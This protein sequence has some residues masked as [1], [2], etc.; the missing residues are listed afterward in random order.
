M[1]HARY[2]LLSLV[3]V[4]CAGNTQ[5]QTVTVPDTTSSG[6]QAPPPAPRDDVSEV[7]APSELVAIVRATNARAIS[8]R[9][10]QLGIATDAQARA[11]ADQ[12]L[13]EFLG[14]RELARA[15]S[16]DQPMD[17][18]VLLGAGRP[19]M[20]LSVGV[21]SPAEVSTRLANSFRA[22]PLGNGVIALDPVQSAQQQ[23][24]SDGQD[25]GEDIV[26]DAMH[27][28]LSPTPTEGQG[29][30][31]C[32]KGAESGLTLVTPFMARTLTRRQTREN[33]IVA[34]V[35]PV[36]MRAL[37]GREATAAFD[38]A[39]R[40]S[41]TMLS[42]Q[43]TGP[44]RHAELR[45]PLARLVGELIANG[46]ATF[47]EL[48]GI[49]MV[50]SMDNDIVRLSQSIELRAPSGSLVRAM[51]DGSRNVPAA[52][53]QHLER[54]A[55]DAGFYFSA[56]LSL[57]PF[58]A[59]LRTVSEAVV[60]LAQREARM[61]AAQ[62]A[63]LRQ[64]AESVTTMSATAVGG[65]VLANTGESSGVSVARF[66]TPA[67]ATAYV[68]DIRR[69]VGLLRSA[70]FARSMQALGTAF[71]VENVPDLRQVRELPTRGLPAGSFAYSLPDLSRVARGARPAARGA[72]P[73]P[74]QQLLVV[75]GDHVTV[76]SGVDMRAAWAAASAR[77]GA[78]PA[79]LASVPVRPG[80][81]TLAMMPSAI[82]NLF[83]MSQ[84]AGSS[85]PPAQPIVVPSQSPLVMRMHNADS[86]GAT[87]FAWDFEI[88]AQALTALVR[89]LAR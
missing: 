42:N 48:S 39:E 66:A 56:G 78:A 57:T 59:T 32:T 69:M 33:A 61:P 43:S 38:Q 60:V 74:T 79:A 75:E 89:T 24:A 11:A 20:V 17:M 30:L 40:Q 29:R 55:P 47:N 31:T 23:A 22:R 76:V 26:E 21:G 10:T 52:P 58:A 9:L 25:E 5:T 16:R 41:A 28:L 62:V 49:D 51:I 73:R 71:D 50:L 2:T 83:A 64:V 1:K 86:D 45:A 12:L 7:A 85:T 72:A 19:M 68:S 44:L 36:A 37:L 81:M 34:T 53:E 87:R 8:E 88:S 82:A 54:I 80:T 67:A 84:N 15:V 14:S 6:N 35:F 3:L 46:R 27:C 18:A 13:T 4:S 65:V 77:T 70:P 63:Q